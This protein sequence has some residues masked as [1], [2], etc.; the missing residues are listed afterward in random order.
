[1]VTVQVRVVNVLA[2]Y[3]TR[4]TFPNLWKQNS[5]NYLCFCSLYALPKLRELKLN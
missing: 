3:C 5:V 1:M 4:K 2:G